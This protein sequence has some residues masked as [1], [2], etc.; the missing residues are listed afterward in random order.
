MQPLFALYFL[1]GRIWEVE[2]EA[3]PDTTAQGKPVSLFTK[4]LS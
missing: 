4:H 1:L 2:E 3:T